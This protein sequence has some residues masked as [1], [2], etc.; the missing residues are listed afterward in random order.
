MSE[1]VAEKRIVNKLPDHIRAA[2]AA[3]IDRIDFAVLAYAA[4]IK[5]SGN[6]AIE[7]IG[8]MEGSDKYFVDI[9]NA[10]YFGKVCVGV[11]KAGVNYRYELPAYKDDIDAL[12]EELP[13]ELKA[14]AKEEAEKAK[15]QSV[16]QAYF[17]MIVDGSLSLDFIKEKGHLRPRQLAFLDKML[18]AQE[19]GEA[20]PEADAELDEA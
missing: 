5:L 13:E 18:K 11:N 15:K 20:V 8:K 16:V 19:A 4:V 3:L 1:E 12:Y 9:L 2:K 14:P 17:Q 7:F 10:L 6:A